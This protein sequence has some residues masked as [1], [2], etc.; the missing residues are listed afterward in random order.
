MRFTYCPDC[1]ALLVPREI[2]DEGIIPY[3]EH[4][5]QPRWD[6]FTTSVIC[7]V[8][9]E[10]GEVALLRQG[11]ISQSYPIC[12]SGILQAGE[13]A[14]TAAA[15]E[16]EEEL[17]LP[18]ESVAYQRSFWFKTKGMLMLGFVVRVRKGDFRLSGEVDG[19][20]WVPL[21]KAPAQMRPGSI[22]RRLVSLAAGLPDP[23]SE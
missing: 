12:V 3:C 22:A 23:G 13:D 9:N 11:Y 15:R 21:P 17:G 18:A 16:V 2:G 4:C 19:A 20:A 5:R 8:V 10:C 7:A 6:M 14:E 1:G